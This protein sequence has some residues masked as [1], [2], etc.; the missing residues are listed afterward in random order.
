[1]R[2]SLPR[3][4]LPLTV[5][6]GTRFSTSSTLVSPYLTISSWLTT[7]LAAVSSRRGS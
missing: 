7:I 4:P 1:M 5:T 2:T 3:P 6:P